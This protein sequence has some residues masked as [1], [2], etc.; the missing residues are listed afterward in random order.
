MDTIEVAVVWPWYSIPR[1][2]C[3]FA[4]KFSFRTEILPSP[5]SICNS[6]F[7]ALH[8]IQHMALYDGIAAISNTN[9]IENTA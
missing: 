4:V 2:R 6:F 8:V 3:I 1:F 9:Y 7:F 5:S